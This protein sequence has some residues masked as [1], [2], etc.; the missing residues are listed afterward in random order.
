MKNELQWFKT[1]KGLKTIVT[2]SI[3]RCH[4]QPHSLLC[5]KNH[6]FIVENIPILNKYVKFIYRSDRSDRM[7][8]Y[9]YVLDQYNKL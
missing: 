8:V 4:L 5:I 2:G 7:C 6:L 3:P 9:I 1:Q